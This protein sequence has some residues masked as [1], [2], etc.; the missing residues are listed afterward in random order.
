MQGGGNPRELK[1]LKGSPL[2]TTDANLYLRVSHA[3]P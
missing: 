1:G 3:P 2:I